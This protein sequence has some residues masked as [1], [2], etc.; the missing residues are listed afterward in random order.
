M[1]TLVTAP[2]AP[3]LAEVISRIGASTTQDVYLNEE[4]SLVLA[5]SWGGS[6]F[7]RGRY[8]GKNV[9]LFKGEE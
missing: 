1:G 6:W 2:A 3:T 5:G 4:D 7:E 8:M 9:Y